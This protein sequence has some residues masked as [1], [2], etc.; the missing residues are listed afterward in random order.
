MKKVVWGFVLLTFLAGAAPAVASEQQQPRRTA[1]AQKS[2]EL[3]QRVQQRRAE[4]QRLTPEQ[5][6][7]R[8]TERAQRVTPERRQQLREK[9][10]A[11]LDRNH[12]GRI[13]RREAVRAR[14]AIRR[15]MRRAI[16]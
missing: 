2:Q 6:Q 15:A 12:D 4:R 11:R 10:L 1:P 5:L 9:R 7:Q 13:S 16:R 8:R 3:R 14:I